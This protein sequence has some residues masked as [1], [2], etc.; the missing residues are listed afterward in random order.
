MKSNLI[1]QAIADAKALRESAYELAKD[2]IAETF[3]PKVQ[4]LIRHKLAEMD[5]DPMEEN[6]DVNEYGDEHE[7]STKDALSGMEEDLDEAA[8]DSLLAELDTEEEMEESYKKDDSKMMQEAE[9]EEAEEAEEEEAEEEE[10]GE[11]E[12]GEEEEKDVAELTVDEL[13]DI[14]ADIIHDTM[15]STESTPPAGE[16]EMDGATMDDEPESEGSG[17]EISLDELLDQLESEDQAAHGTG[18]MESLKRE[19]AA[20]KRT[21][22]KLRAELIETNL[23][24]AK[25]L[26]TTKLSKNLNIT[27]QQI[28]KAVRVFDQAKTVREVKHSYQILSEAYSTVNAKTSSKTK[29]PIKEH[30]SFASRPMHTIKPTT[31]IVEQDR[32]VERWQELAGIKQYR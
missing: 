2:Q 20:A 31:P 23:L 26:Y 29:T 21:V 17:E 8:L 4:E 27:E 10:A 25:L 15:A 3:G 9:E 13:R 19:L 16:E 5:E 1:E 24:N 6:L 28:A 11:E 18:L 32:V 22:S 30:R 14:I 12:A 7:M